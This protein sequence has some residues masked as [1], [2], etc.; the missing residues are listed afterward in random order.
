MPKIIIGFVGQAGAGKGTAADMLAKNSHAEIFTFSDILADVLKRLFKE[1]SRDNLIKAS[2]AIREA[3]GQDALA[4]V[5]EA[6]VQA[7]TAD[8][9]IVDG[10]RR[11]EDI[12]DLSKDSKFHLVE[13]WAPPEIRFERLKNRNEKAGEGDMTW[14]EFLDM[15]KRETEVTIAGVAAQ[16]KH[17]ID[18][19][20]GL[21]DFKA[22]LDEFIATL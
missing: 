20:G 18:N 13:I 8:I 21:E 17:K 16:A 19:S 1:K 15:G 2:T 3:F 5:M 4:N 7:S 14:E 6:Q 22:K 9:V 12:E 10:I 11:M